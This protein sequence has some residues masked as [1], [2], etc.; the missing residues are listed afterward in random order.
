MD[1]MKNCRVL[2]LAGLVTVVPLFAAEEEKKPKPAAPAVQVVLKRVNLPAGQTL[3]EVTTTAAVVDGQVEGKLA[4]NVGTA[5]QPKFWTVNYDSEGEG[6]ILIEVNDSSRLREGIRDGTS[7]VA[8]MELFEVFIPFDGSG[9]VSIYKTKTEA[10]T[11]EITPVAN[12]AK[13]KPAAE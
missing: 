13:E 5:E 7:W 12:A 8:P 3:D 6:W 4:I 10:L 1:P 11:L 2:L 9:T